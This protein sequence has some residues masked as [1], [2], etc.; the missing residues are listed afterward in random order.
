M[1]W[2]WLT[3]RSTVATLVFGYAIFWI[4]KQGIIS[5]SYW[6][7]WLFASFVALLLSWWVVLA[8]IFP[9]DKEEDKSIV[10]LEFNS[11]QL[12]NQLNRLDDEYQEKLD[13]YDTLDDWEKMKLEFRLW[14]IEHKTWFI[15]LRLTQLGNEW[16]H[17]HKTRYINW[18]MLQGLNNARDR[19]AEEVNKRRNKNK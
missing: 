8:R 7:S 1:N 13:L 12:I 16:Y 18:L 15:K 4:D 9:L 19:Y 17:K 3:I 2:T 5:N 14:Q 6:F 10:S 11:Q